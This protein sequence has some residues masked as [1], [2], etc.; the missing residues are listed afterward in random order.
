[1]IEGYGDR[2][3]LGAVTSAASA[4]LNGER[5]ALMQAGEALEAE[6]SAE[7]DPVRR[8]AELKGIDLHGLAAVLDTAARR[9]DQPYAELREAWLD[10]MM[11]ATILRERS[12]PEAVNS[13][14]AEA[15][16]I[17]TLTERERQVISLIGEGLKNR[18]I[19]ER[20]FISEAT[21]RHHLTS[22]FNK[23]GVADRL[24]LVIYAYQHNLAEL[25]R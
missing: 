17:A 23:L 7:P 4:E 19:A 12:R 1:M 8:S 25:P 24:E 21:V 14:N 20:M 10:R 16:K 9:I 18:E 13:R 22:I 5:L 15:A 6:L 11:I 3:E 2:D